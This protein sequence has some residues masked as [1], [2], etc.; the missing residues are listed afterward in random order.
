MDPEALRRFVEN[1]RAASAR[2][3]RE[4]SNRPMPVAEAWASAMALLRFD[5]QMNGDPFNR[6]DPVT[7]WEDR[8]M[9]EATRLAL[10]RQCFASA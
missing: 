2:E 7:E 5:E 8:E 9:Y 4:R 3:D 1:H 6:Y 10:V